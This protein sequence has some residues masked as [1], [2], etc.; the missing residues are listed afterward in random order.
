MQDE[1]TKNEILVQCRDRGDR[2]VDID[3]R[4]GLGA[5]IDRG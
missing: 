4:C 5:M 1:Q 2:G 3:R